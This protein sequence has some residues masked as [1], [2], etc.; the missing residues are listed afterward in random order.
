MRIIGLKEA[1]KDKVREKKLSVAGKGKASFFEL[2]LLKASGRA[3]SKEEAKEI[4]TLLLTLPDSFLKYY[5]IRIQEKVME[6]AKPIIAGQIRAVSARLRTI[7]DK[8]SE[9]EDRKEM[10]RIAMDWLEE[11]GKASKT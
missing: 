10:Y 7:L 9:E 6:Q 5:I 11:K 8:D 3:V 1:L 2:E 4:S